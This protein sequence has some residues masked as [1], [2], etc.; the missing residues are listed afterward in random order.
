M[1]WQTLQFIIGIHPCPVGVYGG[2][3]SL[4]AMLRVATLSAPET[5]ALTHIF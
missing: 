1:A 2:G 4:A 5:V 3:G